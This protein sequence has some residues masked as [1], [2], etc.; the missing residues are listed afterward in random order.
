MICRGMSG[1]PD[2]ISVW[3]SGLCKKSPNHTCVIPNG[4][5]IFGRWLNP[6]PMLNKLS[7]AL[8]LSSFVAVCV[9]FYYQSYRSPKIVY[10]DS[11]R[12]LNGYKGMI[13]AKNVFE[14]SSRVW[15]A[16]VD[17]LTNEVE[18]LIK[19]IETPIH[20]TASSERDLK[21]NSLNI[22]RK[23]LQEYKH[24]INTR[25]KIEEERLVAEV[26]AQIN[27][28]LDEF[29]KKRGYDLIITTN[30]SGSVAFANEKLDVTDEVLR[31]INKEYIG[32]LSDE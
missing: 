12:L 30:E 31:E 3:F 8:T 5:S 17:T 14:S 28:Y 18:S 2:I 13:D 26:L 27:E 9:L 25:A 29:G 1:K 22:K 19:E 32:L 11:D 7:I 4:V 24:A 20:K 21:I 23:Q 15:S 6:K 10:L 16:N